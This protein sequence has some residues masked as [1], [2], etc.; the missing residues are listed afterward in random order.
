MKGDQVFAGWGSWVARFRWPVL[1]V[2]LVAIATAVV[3]PIVWKIFRRI[4][5]AYARMH[6]ER[7]AAPEGIT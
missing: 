5:A 7:D 6:R 4:D 2:A 3:G 1:T